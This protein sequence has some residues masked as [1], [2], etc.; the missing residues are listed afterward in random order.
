MRSNN[1]DVL[2]A[3][4][5]IAVVLYHLGTCEYGYL[6]VDI[7]LVIAGY[8]TSK[9][10]DKQIV[11]RGG[12][13]PYVSNRL[14]R[15]WP[16]LLIAGI[17]ILAWGWMLMLPDDYENMAQSVIA[18]NFFG[19]NVL[20]AITTK[21][22]WDVVNEYKPLMHTWYVGL[23]MQFYVVV[24]LIL[25]SV[26]R[27]I[28]NT[29]KRSKTFSWVMSLLGLASLFLY[30]TSSDNAQKFYYL[31]F[32]LYEFS[33]GALVFYLFDNYKTKP[34]NGMKWNLVFILAYLVVILL[35]FVNADIFSKVA[36]LLMTVGLT[37]LLMALMPRVRVASGNL[38]SNKWIASIGAASFSIFVWHQ[39][40]FALTRYSF[41]SKL[42]DLI[43][44]LSVML[45]TA[46]LSAL[47]YRYIE[48]MKQTRRAW[49]I[50]A[51]LL[52][53]TT[54]YSLYVYSQA[55]VMRDVPELDVVK[56]KVHRGMWAEY[57]DRGYKYDKE[58]T[59]SDKP[60]W[61]VIGNSFGRDFVNII[62]ES[63]IA[64]SVEVVYSDTETYKEK[65]DRFAKADVVFLSSLGVNEELINEVRALCPE[66]CKFY[67]I[68]EK[69][70]GENNGQIYRHRF[71]KDYHEMTIRMEQGYAEKNERL[72]SLYPD[73]YVD[74]IAKVQYPDG[75][76]RVF[77]DDGRFISQDC[78]HLT[79]AG[80]QH[81]AKLMD[82]SIF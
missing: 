19:N 31:P 6:G 56:G 76:V 26:R 44:L 68:G 1:Y 57:C 54:G 50:A 32:R 35:L 53:L 42:T 55:G 8:F 46:L 21:N 22:Y 16:L 51:I 40:V 66:K 70:F 10:I 47:S 69:N 29:D 23:L 18:T 2:K 48:K 61:Y 34:L 74:M 82:W 39:V 37:A 77:S 30:L 20:Q 28:T 67:I 13:L 15:L 81:Y 80:A 41:T 9:S 36:R 33:A 25:F 78:R 12:Y 65:H 58:F 60:K 38:L 43:P 45:L 73:S 49:M 14:F 75:S 3:L 5:I 7:F 11:I 62:A 71:D 27:M 72:K 59:V 24:P 4:A 79:K 17:V 63:A 64:D 52:V